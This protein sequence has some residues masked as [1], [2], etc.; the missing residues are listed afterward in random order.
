VP[1]G[2][3]QS[4]Q[5]TEASGIVPTQTPGVYFTHNDSG[6]TARFFAIDETGSL[7]AEF[8]LAGNPTAID[9]EDI[10]RG[11]C[12]SG[13]CVFLGDIGDNLSTRSG[14]VVYR[15]PEPA[16]PDVDAGPVD[17]T[18]DALPFTYPDGPHNAETLLVHPLTGRLYVITKTFP[19]PSSVFV[20][21]E[22]LTPGAS[23]VLQKV[24]EIAP[25]EENDR[26]LTAGDIHPSGARL[27]LRTYGAV[28]ELRGQVG[29]AFETVLAQPWQHV[30]TPPEIQGEGL[31]YLA[32]GLGY[33]TIAEGQHPTPYRTGCR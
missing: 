4:D 15:F 32:D 33:V 10:S 6:D 1:L 22:P 31:A 16:L 19:G 8:H 25:P 17:L 23:V 13:T 9:I 24:T 28:W 26:Q 21:P 30:P 12:P 27:L 5:I 29:D 3:V 2:T 11:P 20:F 14:C 18:F 7:R